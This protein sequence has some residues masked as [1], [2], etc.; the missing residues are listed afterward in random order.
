MVGSLTRRHLVL[1]E[2]VH[3][4]VAGMPDNGEDYHSQFIDVDANISITLDTSHPF[5]H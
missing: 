2:S 1:F 4:P 5:E 3:V